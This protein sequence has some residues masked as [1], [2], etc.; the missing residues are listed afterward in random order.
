[1]HGYLLECADPVCSSIA[2]RSIAWLFGNSSSAAVDQPAVSATGI[3]ASPNPFSGISH[4]Q[5]T[6]AQDELNV[7]F[8]AY[9]L[10]GRQVATLAT[11]NEGGN[12]YS[13][14][15]DASKLADGTYTIVAHS[16]KGTHQIRVVNQQ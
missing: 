10:L 12:V 11:S 6:A 13:A 4:I 9:D 3:T 5:Y 7:T 2:G 14:A 15:F 1:M 16:S 8:A